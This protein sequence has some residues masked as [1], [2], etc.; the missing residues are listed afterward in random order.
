M[1]KDEFYKDA[2]ADVTGPLHGVRVLDVTTTWAGPMAGCVLGDL[3]ADVIKV[4]IPGG[5]VL[6]AA[7]PTLPG[8]ADRKLGFETVNRNK[9]AISLDLRQSE[10]RELFLELAKTADMVVQNFLPGTF[11]R[12]G[13]GYEGVKAVKPDIIYVSISG[14][15]QFGDQHAQAGYDPIALATSGWMSLNGPRDGVPNKAPTYLADDLAGVHAALGAVA[16]LRYRDQTG[17]GQHVDSSL[18][19][20]TLFQS[21][22]LLTYGALGGDL[23]RWGNEVAVCAPTN[24]FEAADG[25]VFIALILDPH[26]VNLC[27]VVERPEAGTAPHLATNERRCENRD[28]V[29][30]IVSAWTVTRSSAEVVEILREAG[31][32]AAKVQSFGEAANM[33]HVWDRDA[34]QPTEL[35]DGSTVP[36]TGPPVKFSR[37]PTSVR[38]RAPEV[39]EHNA[40]VY[41]DIGLDAGRLAE[42]TRRGI[43]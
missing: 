7:P 39:G 16:A 27:R 32:A 18:L 25:Y 15:G 41:A 4:E 24:V 28:E 5:E 19:D 11:D 36:L 10:G 21:N 14:W 29:N 20:A 40:E 3:G 42:L 30:G 34:L 37:T 23:E 8:T 31:I 13:V 2:R 33:A 38:M 17:E 12:W 6:R 35:A 1:E 43:I 9:R 22:G 26:W